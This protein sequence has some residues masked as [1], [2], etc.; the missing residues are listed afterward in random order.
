MPNPIALCHEHK[1]D[2]CSTYVEHLLIGACVGELCTR[3]DGLKAW[4]DHGWPATMNNIHRD[5]GE[6]L[7]IKL[8]TACDLCDVRDNEVDCK[9]WEISGLHARL[10]EEH[11]L[12]RRIEEWLARYKG[13]QR[14][15]LEVTMGSPL[16]CKHQAVGAL[17]PPLLPAVYM[18]AEIPA[19]VDIPLPQKSTDGCGAHVIRDPMEDIFNLEDTSE[20][21]TNDTPDPLKKRLKKKKSQ[22][23]L[24]NCLEPHPLEPQYV[25]MSPVVEQGANTCPVEKQGAT[26]CPCCKAGCETK[27]GSFATDVHYWT[28]T[29]PSGQGS[30][31][32]CHLSSTMV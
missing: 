23:S 13:K 9:W 6:P 22:G 11:R 15:E 25:D 26:M 17:L 16:P 12:Q 4:L 18:L 21:S 24:A 31:N 2:K 3:P 8:D 1:C 10:T 14:E 19:E 32:S 28:A 27:T 29:P 7:A 5:V 20:S 30:S